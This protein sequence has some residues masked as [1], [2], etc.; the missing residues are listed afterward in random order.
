[1]DKFGNYKTEAW[2]KASTKKAKYTIKIDSGEYVEAQVRAYGQNKS[3]SDWT[4]VEAINSLAVPTNIKAVNDTKKDA[5]KITWKKVS[6]AKYYKVYRSTRMGVYNATENKYEALGDY[7][8][9]EANDNTYQDAYSN[10]TVSYSEYYD[11]SGSIVGNKAYDYDKL[12][13]GVKY[14]YY[15]VAF[16]EKGTTI[17]SY[18]ASSNYYIDDYASGKPASIVADA[19]ITI[20]LANK[21]AKKVTISY[22]KVKGAKSY[23]IF[24]ATKKNGEYKLLKSTKKTTFTDTTAKKGKTYYYK[25]IA[26]GTNALKADLVVESAV[27]SIKVKK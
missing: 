20:K 13:P 26:T 3:Y 5:V 24:R 23:K 16:G 17:A 7:I 8:A 15:V 2:Q 18:T 9:K 27:K 25:V 22:N 14:Y 1:V 10:N 6:G 19:D 11:I 21:K 12:E 4:G